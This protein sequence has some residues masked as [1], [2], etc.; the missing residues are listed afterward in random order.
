MM[1]QKILFSFVLMFL[2]FST[3]EPAVAFENKITS[4]AEL[5]NNMYVRIKCEKVGYLR[6]VQKTGR[7]VLRGGG[8]PEA[9]NTVFQI[10]TLPGNA[11][12]IG[13]KCLQAQNFNLQVCMSGW[14]CGF[15]YVG[16]LR[17]ANANFSNWEH[18]ILVT[19]FRDMTLPPGQFFL[20]NKDYNGYLSLL[21]YAIGGTDR[22]AFDVDMEWDGYLA[23]GARPY[24]IELEKVRMK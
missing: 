5:T 19:K 16:E 17:F 18:F 23:K 12:I 22:T 14:I 9:D 6:P 1:Y 7:W 11:E 20:Y 10:L 15:P 21:P 4:R 8:N 2:G 13:I 24:S 3:L